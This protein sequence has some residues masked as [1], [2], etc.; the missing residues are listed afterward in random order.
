MNKKEHDIS[1]PERDLARGLAH[2]ASYQA[3]M[4]EMKLI[5]MPLRLSFLEAP[6]AESI[7][8]HVFVSGK[9]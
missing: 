3:H 6:L 1:Q 4:L 8:A 5:I 9:V 2:L 7:S